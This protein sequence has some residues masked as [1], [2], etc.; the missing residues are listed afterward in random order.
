MARKLSQAQKDMEEAYKQG[1]RNLAD[2]HRKKY[3][4]TSEE[5]KQM[6]KM[7]YCVGCDMPIR[8]CEC[9]LADPGN[10]QAVRQ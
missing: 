8:K 9:E 4:F 1:L 7:N 5:L 6:H 3:R 10:L 2:L